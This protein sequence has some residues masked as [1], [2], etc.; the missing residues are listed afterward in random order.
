MKHYK[1][2]S[3]FFKKNSLYFVLFGFILTVLI[4]V[5]LVVYTVINNN[6]NET[7]TSITDS[8]IVT[9]SVVQSDI[10]TYYKED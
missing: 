7:T 6:Q 3:N 8:G 10:Q 4:G 1:R 9:I 2:K 5:F